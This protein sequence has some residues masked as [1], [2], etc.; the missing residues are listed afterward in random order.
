MPVE[1]IDGEKCITFNFVPDESQNPAFATWSVH[2]LDDVEIDESAKN[3]IAKKMIE[4]G[5]LG[6]GK[7]NGSM[8]ADHAWD[9]WLRDL[10][11]RASWIDGRARVAFEK[12]LQEFVSATTTLWR[13]KGVFSENDIVD[14]SLAASAG[15]KRKRGIHRTYQI[16][17]W[18]KD[19]AKK[20]NF[21]YK[22]EFQD[23]VKSYPV[24]SLVDNFRISASTNGF[25]AEQMQS[26][27]KVL[28]A[29]KRELVA[30]T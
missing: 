15:K 8:E 21:N 30:E 18:A 28:E 4:Y 17:Q 10:G 3:M 13:S 7:S 9:I 1:K 12:A 16:Q 2:M 23:R 24:A 27:K 25:T 14:Q 5:H 20:D 6:G 26:I 29:K 22:M 19:H 11:F